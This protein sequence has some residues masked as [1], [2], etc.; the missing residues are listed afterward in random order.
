MIGVYHSV[1]LEEVRYALGNYIKRITSVGS[2]DGRNQGTITG[3][4]L[5]SYKCPHN[6]LEATHLDTSSDPVPPVLFRIEV[7][8][9]KAA[10]VLEETVLWS[11]EVYP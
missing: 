8:S 7:V 3:I 2:H 11:K 4:I 10:H 9:K 1:R 5:H 6:E